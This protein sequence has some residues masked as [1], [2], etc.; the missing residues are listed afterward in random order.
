MLRKMKQKIMISQFQ[1]KSESNF[2]SILDTNIQE[3]F[4]KLQEWF[5]KG[6]AFPML[7]KIKKLHKN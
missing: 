1:K 7:T 5:V 3:K 2:V 6:F 4:E